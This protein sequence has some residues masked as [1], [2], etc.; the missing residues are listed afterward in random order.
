MLVRSSSRYLSEYSK[1]VSFAFFSCNSR[2]AREKRNTEAS[3][4]QCVKMTK[5]G[6]IYFLNNKNLL[7]LAADS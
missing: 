2:V 3:E 6:G 5:R 7:P 4:Y 1:R